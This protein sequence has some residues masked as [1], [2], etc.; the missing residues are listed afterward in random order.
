MNKPLSKTAA[1][2]EAR[3]LV[4]R[5]QEFG[6]TEYVVY[7]PARDNDPYGPTTCAQDNSYFDARERRTAWVA[8]VAMALMGHDSDDAGYE[9]DNAAREHGMARNSV[10]A[11]VDAALQAMRRQATNIGAN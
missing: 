2:K 8:R 5:P 11:I 1:I 4:S 6:A 9:V 10:E 3:S 7:G